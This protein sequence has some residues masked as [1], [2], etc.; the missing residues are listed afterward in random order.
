MH[1]AHRLGRGQGPAVGE[2][3]FNCL[4]LHDNAQDIR[5]TTST[6]KISVNPC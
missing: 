4:R 2:V 6:F 3:T 1:H 5:N